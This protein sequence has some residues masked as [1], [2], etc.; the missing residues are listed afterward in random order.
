MSTNPLLLVSGIWMS[1]LCWSAKLRSEMPKKNLRTEGEQSQI[2]S[3][4][5]AFAQRDGVVACVT[6]RNQCE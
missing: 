3:Y 2:K 1:E 6:I 4:W 5:P